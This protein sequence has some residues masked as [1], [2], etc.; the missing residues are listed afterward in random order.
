[1]LV[2]KMKTFRDN[3]HGYIKIPVEYVVNL[4]DTEAF[5]RLR[6]IE[7]TG[8]RV[9]YPSA[10]HDRFIHSL[11]TFHLGKKAF[12]N[13]KR[14]VFDGGA[15]NRGNHYK[16]IK[17][18]KKRNEEFWDWCQI[19]FEVAC[20]LHDCGHAPFSHSLEFFYDIELRERK[21]LKQVLVECVDSKEF[22]RDFNG[23]GT[24][25][26]RMSGLLVCTEFRGAIERILKT[27]ELSGQNFGNSVEF[28]VRMIIG[29]RYVGNSPMNQIKNCLIELLNSSSIDVDSLDYIV[30]DAKLSGIDNMN[31]DIDRLLG[32]LT[33]VE[34]TTFENCK[35]NK[36]RISASVIDGMLET[37]DN[38]AVV[39]GRCRGKFEVV[40]MCTGQL[41]ADG[42]FDFAGTLINTKQ[43]IPVRPLFAEKRSV[44]VNGIHDEKLMKV[45][46]PISVE[47][48]G[49]F[50]GNLEMSGSD[51]VFGENTDAS[52]NLVVSNM[53]GE[54]GLSG[55]S[56]SSAYIEGD[57]TGRFRGTLVG[58]FT[59]IPGGKLQCCLGYHKSSLSVIQNVITARNY[60]Y[61]W[62]YSHHKVV[63]YSNYLLVDLLRGCIRFI[64]GNQKNEEGICESDNIIARMLSYETIA[65]YQK[66]RREAFTFHNIN[67]LRPM[68]ADLIS[69][70]K[71]VWLDKRLETDSQLYRL[72]NEYYTRKYKKS[73]WKSYAEFSMFFSGFTNEEVRL[74]YY[75]L[76]E[77]SHGD[78][79]KNYGYI[80]GDVENVFLECGMQNVVWVNGD[81]KHKTLQ[82]DRVFVLFN[83][84][85]F[86]YRTISSS[87]DIRFYTKTDIFYLY[88]ETVEGKEVDVKR[89]KEFF[90]NVTKEKM[91]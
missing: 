77:S 22:E 35:F 42:H 48:C 61:Q 3:V 73:L 20:L 4:I 68:D 26:E 69:L 18:L 78:E 55:I 81:V 90:G 21:N 75:K 11:G 60:E 58:N 91:R 72:F 63:Y 62:I 57:L 24:P 32:S 49:I 6:N 33:L 10:R 89:L 70:F 2:Q 5:Q 23:E 64:Q 84:G 8:M 16:V 47:V 52:V 34:T 74:I 67:F 41:Y 79:R 31:V 9:L 40:G 85:V 88:Y 59:D 13:F 28:V 39:E 50:G 17:R 65:M 83:E 27:H 56:M 25:H 12:S 19:L 51:L 82:P 29:C 44:S 15:E 71:M 30:R 37:G 86:T 7:Q 66:E 14:N 45:N 36:Q 54:K 1:M 43:E 80:S 76:V 38:R 53:Q 46:Q 87:N